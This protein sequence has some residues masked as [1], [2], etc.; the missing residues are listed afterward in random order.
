MAIGQ[1]IFPQKLKNRPHDVVGI[2]ISFFVYWHTV[3]D[4]ILA[5]LTE[6]RA[7]PT[8]HQN[9]NFLTNLAWL[10]CYNS[11]SFLSLWLSCQ[12][13][14]K[15]SP[16]NPL[17]NP[18]KHPPKKADGQGLGGFW[19]WWGFWWWRWSFIRPPLPPPTALPIRWRWVRATLIKACL[20]IKNGKAPLLPHR[21]PHGCT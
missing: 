4:E 7:I 17:P 14:P 8:N 3:A 5:M 16:S 2:F 20:S 6:C 1:R 15:N 12:A 18:P 21:L 11:S 13:K 19:C 9:H 10:F